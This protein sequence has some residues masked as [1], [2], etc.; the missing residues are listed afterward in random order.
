[1][2]VAQAWQR[3]LSKSGDPAVEVNMYQWAE[4]LTMETIGQSK[5][6]ILY[7]VCTETNIQA[8]AFGVR[9]NA[10]EGEKHELAR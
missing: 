5:I 10:I 8:A 6:T 4:C 7:L 1:L 9:F 2:K 3:L